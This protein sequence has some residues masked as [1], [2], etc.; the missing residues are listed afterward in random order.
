M[1]I[2]N[3]CLLLAAF[4][5][6][7]P[8]QAPG[9]E[10]GTD[11]DSIERA[12]VESIERAKA[13]DL[14]KREQ[15]IQSIKR[16][17]PMLF[18]SQG[19]PSKVIKELKQFGC[20]IPQSGSKYKHGPHNIISGGFAKRGQKDWA[21]LCSR[22]GT[23]TVLLFW[24]GNNT[25]PTELEPIGDSKM[26]WNLYDE[27]GEY[28]YSRIISAANEKYIT[29]HNSNPD[30]PTKPPPITHE[31]IFVDHVTIAYCHDGKWLE[32]DGGD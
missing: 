2:I 19:V 9:V 22:N 6:L 25:C 10:G 11:A 28:R 3:C 23:S 26:I 31:G 24:G 14:R 29:A 5:S 32:L 8:T 16:L 7:I 1:R 12:N 4:T 13:D 30:A 15:G 18:Q 17:D 27:S 20:A 21:A